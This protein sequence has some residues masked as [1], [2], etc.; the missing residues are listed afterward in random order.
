M[1]LVRA[2][3]ADTGF[4]PTNDW[5]S[6]LS[7]NT[8]D[9]FDAQRTL[10]GKPVGRTLVHSVVN[11]T[12]NCRSCAHIAAGG[13]FGIALAKAANDCDCGKGDWC[14]QYGEKFLAA[15]RPA[16]NPDEPTPSWDR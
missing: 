6:H 15:Q 8:L 14:P 13:A 2:A 10:C 12:P 9:D 1:D 4:E 7:V 5:T 16:R 3:G 11:F